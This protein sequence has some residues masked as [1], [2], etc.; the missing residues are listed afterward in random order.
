MNSGQGCLI[1][2]LRYY[3]PLTFLIRQLFPNKFDKIKA[4]VSPIERM[5]INNKNTYLGALD[6]KE[7]ILFGS[8]YLNI[9][10]KHFNLIYEF[11]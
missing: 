8:K 3:L 2:T 11:Y 6:V 9:F 7:K 5:I 10:N 4:S 1:F